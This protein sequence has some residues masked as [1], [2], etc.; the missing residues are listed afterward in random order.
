MALA[1]ETR[2]RQILRDLLVNAERYGGSSVDVT[3]ARN[4]GVATITVAD[5]GPGIGDVDD[6]AILEPYVIAT[7]DTAQPASVGLGLAVARDLARLM[8]GA[9]IYERRA[10]WTRFILTLPM[11]EADTPGPDLHES[12]AAS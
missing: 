3:I 7:H 8:L 11:P 4:D 2:F 10:G 9:L 1:V 12:A 5:D 6:D